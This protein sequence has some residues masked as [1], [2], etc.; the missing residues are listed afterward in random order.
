MAAGVD[1]AQE[2]GVTIEEKAEAKDHLIAQYV[3]KTPGT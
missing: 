3:A 2:E 1:A